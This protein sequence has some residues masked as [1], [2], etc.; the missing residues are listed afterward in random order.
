MTG[1]K[2]ARR[3][4]MGKKKREVKRNASAIWREKNQTRHCVMGICRE[5]IKIDR[6]DLIVE[7]LMSLR[8]QNV[9]YA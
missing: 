3:V 2:S 9:F 8:T 6:I 5:F 1:V 4:K 7:G